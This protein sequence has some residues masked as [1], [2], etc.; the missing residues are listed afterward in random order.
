[1]ENKELWMNHRKI[2]EKGLIVPYLRE[3]QYN[4]TECISS[5]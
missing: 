1:M 4:L 2:D 5:L 3:R